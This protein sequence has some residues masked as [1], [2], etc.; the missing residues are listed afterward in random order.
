MSRILILAK[1]L[2]C[3][4]GPEVGKQEE[5]PQR[6]EPQQEPC[7]SERVGHLIDMD[8]VSML[9]QQKLTILRIM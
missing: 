5:E 4:M 9:I 8:S 7:R 1:Q 6:D 3:D 2:L